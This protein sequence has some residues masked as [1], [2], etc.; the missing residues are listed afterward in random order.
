MLRVRLL[1]GLDA[2]CAGRSLR[3]PTRKVAGLLALLAIRP[4]LPLPRGRL[5]AV[6]WPDGDEAASRTSLRQALAAL[7][8]E[9]GDLLRA[10]GDAVSLEADSDVARLEAALARG[11][12]L[13][14]AELHT[15]PLL[16]GIDPGTEPFE[17]WRRAEAAR[18]RDRIIAALTGALTG[19]L[20]DASDGQPHA[21]ALLRLDPAAEEAHQA[22]IRL[23]L[24]RGALG[25]AMRQYE[26]CRETLARDL[27]VA[28]SAETEALR[29]RIRAPRPAEDETRPTLAVMPFTDLSEDPGHAWF[30]PALAEDLTAE[31]GRFRVLR[32]IAAASVLAVRPHAASPREA[33]ERLGARYLLTGS[34]RRGP[35]Q[36]RL[37]ADLTD[38][39]EGRHLWSQRLDLPLEQLQAATDELVAAVAGSLAK[40]LEHDLVQEA[41]AKPA[42]DLA[43]WE[44]WLRGLSL[45]RSGEASQQAEA[46]ALFTRAL[47]LDPGFARAEAGLSL[48]Q[49]N[50]WSCMAWDQWEERERRAHAHALRAVALDE[51]DSMA[52]F[53]LGRVLLYRRD[54]GRGAHH[55]AR[56]EALNPNDADMQ[57]QMALAHCILGR[58]DRAQQAADLAARLNPFH[59]D[60]YFAYAAMPPFCLGD[61]ARA[62]ELGSR[63]PEVAADMD[64]YRAA[65]EAHLGRMAEARASLARFLHRFRERITFGRDPAPG[66]PARWLALV[67][68]F[69]RPEDLARLLDGVRLA[70]LEVPEPVRAPAQ[71]T[72]R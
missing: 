52:H 38:A 6:L 50:E 33:A 69:A 5:A 56:A 25:A 68:P 7:R 44:C 36:V 3:L 30:A 54:F 26:R 20:A 11:D 57:T 67:N 40:R 34:V 71:A 31:L 14:A 65:A 39:L 59:D 45:L 61:Y 28:P 9:V 24:G 22:L 53:I 18:L 19:T 62:I 51:A 10:E 66:E 58:P 63:A 2:E 37:A 48:V 12:A 47:A 23:H 13:A 42:A 8:R 17:D 55:L 43:A 60:W 46:E 29:R 72:A 64:A 16:D 1:G 35:A 32:V 49:F 41:R 27:G 15:G 21:E 70:G 4:G